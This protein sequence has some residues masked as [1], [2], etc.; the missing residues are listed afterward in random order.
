MSDQGTQSADDSRPK[1]EIGWVIEADLTDELREA[2]KTTVTRL[3][4]F[5]QDCM[6]MFNWIF[7]T[8]ERPLERGDGRAEPVQLLD[9]VEIDRDTRGW[10]FAFVL[11]GRKLHGREKAQVL[12]MTSGI[13]STALISTA[14]LNSRASP[15]KGSAA[16]RLYA[17]SMHLFAR[18]NGLSPDRSD[19][20]MRSV[21]APEDLDRMNGLNAPA[22]DQLTENMKDVADL[23]AEEMLEPEHG[24][25]RFYLRSIWLNRGTLPDAILRMR[26][27]VL[28]LRLP[29]LTTA[30]GSALA[31]LLMTAESWEV[32]ANLSAGALIVLSVLA[33]AATSTYL[34]K[35]Q[36]LLASRQGPLREQRAVSNAGTV[37]AIVFGMGVTYLGVFAIAYLLA[38]GLFGNGLL[39]RWVGESALPLV[40]LSISGLVASLSLVIGALGASFEPYGYFRH[41][42]QIDDEI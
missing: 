39:E 13:F 21:N 26:P 12:G 9:A 40:R 5:L 28:P 17:L 3:E 42:T 1:V 35:A 22:I 20:F 27:W 2:A 36:R 16:Q 34:L 33:L 24:S 18:L 25:I 15:E 41:V 37:L 14:F 10:D 23:R 30:A 8:L 19:T 4:S 7:D 29:R 11:T 31:V 6:P 32:A 38:V